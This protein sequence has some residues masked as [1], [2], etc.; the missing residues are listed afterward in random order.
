MESSKTDIQQPLTSKHVE[1]SRDLPPVASKA[2]ARTLQDL[3][4][5]FVLFTPA[6]IVTHARF[7]RD[8]VAVFSQQRS[9]EE[10]PSAI[11]SQRPFFQDLPSTPIKWNNRLYM[12]RKDLWEECRDFIARMVIS[13]PKTQLYSEI[14]FGDLIIVDPL[15]LALRPAADELPTVSISTFCVTTNKFFAGLSPAIDPPRTRAFPLL[16]APDQ[17]IVERGLNWFSKGFPL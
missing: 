13:D 3:T 14:G 10:S 1:E 5:E 2:P 11:N 15:A 9:P 17:A 16:Q 7:D 6:L 4:G 12:I 8:P